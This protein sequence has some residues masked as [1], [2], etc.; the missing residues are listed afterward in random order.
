MSK[1]GSKEDVQMRVALA[2]RRREDA[3]RL[4]A[5]GNVASADRMFESA[6]HMFVSAAERFMHGNEGV[7][8]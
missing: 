1:A 8:P 7:K 2:E 3:R 4:F 6:E 5:I